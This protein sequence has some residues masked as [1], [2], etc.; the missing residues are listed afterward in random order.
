MSVCEGLGKL[1]DWTTKFTQS[2]QQRGIKLEK[3]KQKQIVLRTSWMIKIVLSLYH[4]SPRRTGEQ[5]TNSIRR[6]NGWKFPKFDK[7]TLLTQSRNWTNTKED[8]VKEIHAKT[9][10]YT[11]EN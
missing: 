3:Q 5:S 2:E 10:N 4:Q 11:F 9:H 8:Q 6:L 7:D 1:E